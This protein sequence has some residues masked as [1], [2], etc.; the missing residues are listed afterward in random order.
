[1]TICDGD[2]TLFCHADF[3]P[4]TSLTKTLSAPVTELA[5]FYFEGAPQADYLQNVGKFAETL[6]REKPEGFL[7]AAY[8]LTH[9][10]LEREGVKGKAL[11]LTIGW[12]S[13][14][15]HMEYRETEAFRTN[16]GLLRGDAKGIVMK[17]VQFM[18]AV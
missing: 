3:Q 6:E 8:G 11:V 18:N 7:A 5:T 15:R 13:V 17:H 1:M 9:E 2:P 4:P 12:Q 10:V 14:E 16:I